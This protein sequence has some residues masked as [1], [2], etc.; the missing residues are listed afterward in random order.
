MVGGRVHII[1][2]VVERSFT[3]RGEYF[4]FPYVNF[5]VGSVDGFFEVVVCLVVEVSCEIGCAC[6]VLAAVVVVR[7]VG[8][9]VVGIVVVV[10]CTTLAWVIV[11]MVV[12]VG[13]GV[14]LCVGTM[15]GVTFRRVLL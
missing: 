7:I 2:S 8:V 10:V 1:F 13:I 3:G 5:V 15:A 14:V 9:V 11:E 4:I 12:V 6:D